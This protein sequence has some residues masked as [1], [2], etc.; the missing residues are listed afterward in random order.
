M[1]EPSKPTEGRADDTNTILFTLAEAA[2]ALGFSARGKA[3][4]SVTAVCIDSRLAAPGSLFVAL[5]GEKADG[6][7]FVEAA[8]GRGAL[9][10]MVSAEGYS[11]R[12][13]LYER[14]CAEKGLS[15]LVTKAGVAPLRAFQDLAAWYVS[16][17]PALIKV[18]ITGSSGKTTSKEM[19]KSILSQKY[20]VVSTLGNLN[21]E[22]GLPLSVFQIRA[23]HE[24]GVFELGMNRV[25]EIL[26]TARVLKPS[27]ALITNIG[28]AHIGILGSQDGIAKEKK[29]IFAFFDGKGA[30]F[31]P[32]DE[33][34]LRFLSKGVKGTVFTYGPS[35]TPGFKGSRNLGLDGS[36]IDWEGSQIKLPLPGR[37]NVQN[38]LGAIR[39][40]RH[41]NCSV[42][43]VKAGLEGLSAGFGRAEVVH[44]AVTLFQ[45]CYNANL[46]SVEASLDFADSL[47]WAAGRKVF[48]LGSLLELGAESEATHA[49]IGRRAAASSADA[50][51]FFGPEMEA[52]YKA[53]AAKKFPGRAVWS[54]DF[55]E[56]RAE[57][58]SYLAAG[59]FLLLK[60][61]RG[62]ALERFSEVVAARF[63]KDCGAGAPC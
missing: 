41:L 48:V 40:A 52:A 25:G 53:A 32:E 56:L 7:D 59:D 49:E 43:E 31:I 11:Q 20:R 23:E 15:F 4:A 42:A 3:T 58:V 1:T 35:S 21:S 55:E 60:G 18:G 38:A 47:E 45:D 51:F 9:A 39:V 8:A 24:V 27:L 37:H 16:Q 13:S 10:M 62:M 14:L 50:L 29:N 12:A 44:G 46:E 2:A 57:L 34:Y 17:F 19:V 5:P 30:A 36:A 33:P 6:H 22:T 26:E 61:S 63:N 54:A 28:T